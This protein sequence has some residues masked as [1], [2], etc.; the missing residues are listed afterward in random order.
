MTTRR[1]T[2]RFLA[3]LGAAPVLAS[4]VGCAGS[5]LDEKADNKPTGPI[6]IGLLLPQSGPYKALGDD[7]V[8]GWELYLESR[9]G[10]LGGHP[11]TVIAADE[12]EGKQSALN[13]VKK[14]LDKD[15]VTVLAG[16]GTADTVE[17][18]KTLV[19]ERKVPLVGSGGR[20]STL[21]D[22]SY[23]WHTSW[24]SRET[25]QAIADHLRTTVNGPIYVIGPDYQ[26][27]WDQIGGFVDTFTAGG[28]KLANDGGKPTWTPWPN[29]TNFLPYLNKIT[30]SG[31]KAVYC[32]YA[33]TA[34]VEFVKQYAQA[35]LQGKMPL[36]G[37]GF[38]TEGA[39]LAPQGAAADGVRTVL[40][41]APNLDNPANREFA[42]AYQ[43]K[44]QAAPNIY[45]V[46]GYD[47]A[48]VLDR[49]IAA[50]G[51]N[52]TSESINA[53]IG[54]LGAIDSPRGQWRFGANHSPIQPW[55]LRE[56]RN[57]G[58]ARANVVVQNLTTLGS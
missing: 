54:K 58:R 27:G 33:G 56:V 46:T 40:N 38:L 29:T 6:K 1:Q 39:V 5:S 49:A 48:L 8:R 26:G 28:G 13:A 15:Q 52:P 21:S 19:T 47:T 4:T 17:T 44:H 22:V 14:L 25:G 7:M 41:Y 24:L 3:A 20:P 30:S 2:L 53:A 57:D 36:Y 10:K 11:V 12:A 18:I 16:T 42:A 45:N 51:V 35:R 37:A 50:A 32:F 43:Q 31:A 55:Y 23:I 34:A 9:G